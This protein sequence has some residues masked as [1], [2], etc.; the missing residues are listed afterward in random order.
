MPRRR[1]S[2]IEQYLRNAR[3]VSENER[4][5][6]ESASYADG[7]V[8]GERMRRCGEP[9]LLKLDGVCY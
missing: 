4:T 9:G 2:Q 5:E 7:D 3:E 8:V 6:S 1:S